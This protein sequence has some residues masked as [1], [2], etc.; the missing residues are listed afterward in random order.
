[1]NNADQSTLTKMVVSRYVMAFL[2]IAA[3]IFLPAL[4]LRYWQGWLYM[5]ILFIPML[6][7]MVYMLRNAPDL[8]ERRLRMRERE[9]QQKKI[10][11]LSYIPFFAAY[12]LP[13]FD[14]R[15]GWSN[16]PAWV[17]IAA[18]LVVLAGYAIV[19]LVFRENQYASRV[20]EVE[21]EQS[22]ISSGPYGVVR[23]PMYVGMI[24]LYV[25]SPLVLGSYWAMIPALFILPV[26]VA[27]ILNEEKVLARDL[28]GYPEYM[29]NVRY[30]LVPGVW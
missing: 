20:V 19:F 17:S 26:I 30:R 25:F 18:A 4:T 11:A 14:V 16:V 8:L 13:G 24:L 29:R 2:A 27:R 12:I 6:F 21:K 28:N 9:T 15:L 5:A 3:I 10:I 1:M 23:H 7:V 22:V